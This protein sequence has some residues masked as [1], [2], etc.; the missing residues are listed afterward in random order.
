VVEVDVLELCGALSSEVSALRA[1][2]SLIKSQR[3]T[4]LRGN[5]LTWIQVAYTIKFRYYYTPYT[6]YT[7]YTE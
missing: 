5:L 4:E 6:P 2:L 1:E 7:P 3:E